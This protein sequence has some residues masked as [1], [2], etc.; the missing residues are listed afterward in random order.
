MRRVERTAMAAAILSLT[1]AANW[2]GIFEG[3]D[4]LFYDTQLRLQV[5]PAPPDIV[6]VAVDEKSLEALGPWPWSRDIHAALVHRLSA[7]GARA[8]A[9]DILFPAADSTKAEDAL[10]REALEEYGRVVLAVAPTASA[11]EYGLREIIPPRSLASAAARL[12]HTDLEVDGDGLIRSVYLRAGLGEPI[13]PQLA[14]ALLEVAGS[15][16]SAL[17]GETAH[18]ALSMPRDT[19]IRSHRIRIPFSGPPGTFA[20]FSYVDVLDG[21]APAGRFAGALVIVG[22]TAAGLGREFSTPLTDRH[23]LMSGIEI[24]ANVAAALR[25]GMAIIG[26]P[27]QWTLLFTLGAVTGALFLNDRLTARWA[28]AATLCCG[29]GTMA[30]SFLLIRWFG[31][32]FPPTAAI[33]GSLLVYPLW[34]WRR[35]EATHRA[36]ARDRSWLQVTLDSVGDGVVVVDHRQRIEF[37]NPVAELLTGVSLRE[38]RGRPWD[39]VIRLEDESAGGSPTERTLCCL[40]N[41]TAVPLGTQTALVARDGTR[42]AVHALAAPLRSENGNDRGCVITLTDITDLRRLTDRLG[43]QATHDELTGLPNRTLLRDRLQKSIERARRSS[44][45]V[46]ILFLDLDDFKRVND[47]LGHSV[48]DQLLLHVADRLRA[49]CRQQDTLARLGGDEF[50]FVL[51]DLTHPEQ[52]G[53]VASQLIDALR[54]PI[55]VGEHEF[56]VSASIG[57]AL[58]PK[59]ADDAETLMRLA[60]AAMYHAKGTGRGSFRYASED[61]DTLLLE[62]LSLEAELRNAISAG[63]LQLHY[64][65]VVELHSGRILA[66][67]ALLRWKHPRYGMMAPERFIRLAEETGLITELGRWALREGCRQLRAWDERAVSLPRVALNISPLQFNGPELTEAVHDALEATT[68]SPHRLELELTE[69]MV[70]NDV[71]HTLSVIDRLKTLGVR[72]AID[73]FGTG[74]SSLSYL[75]QFPLDHLKIDRSFIADLPADNESQ[76]IVQAI[77]SLAH[78][79]GMRVI[80]E[81]V[82]TKQQLLFLKQAGCDGVQG[83]FIG[84]PMPSDRFETHWRSKPSVPS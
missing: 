33:L 74:Y 51:D 73:D 41:D 8:V 17:P 27:I 62:R 49:R 46:A 66:A 30:L 10:F 60:D 82:E 84:H 65:P 19:W 54:S 47:A 26:L 11:D 53:M 15:A 78:G 28:L 71:P 76:A 52:A 24:H 59:D 77:V 48:G 61:L 45:L 35:L 72:L 80:A 38:A 6:L 40:K 67:E 56:L 50:V 7:W 29:L 83:Y 25:N 31:L 9:F 16:P 2:M 4:N 21:S 3:L 22:A 44:H 12:G 39:E 57:I 70:M 14:L 63:Q 42:H 23:R 37:I 58:F 20:S 36:L 13:R 18:T 69:S 5:R 81:G 79:L 68:L 34:T 64:Q 75:K 43:F 55:R 1:L 32:W